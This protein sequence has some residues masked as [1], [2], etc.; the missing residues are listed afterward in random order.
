MPW[1]DAFG[2]RGGPVGHGREVAQDVGLHW[3]VA[4]LAVPA[5]WSP[6]TQ[7]LPGFDVEPVAV[8]CGV[9]RL[10][11]HR[12]PAVVAESDSDPCGGGPD[13]QFAGAPLTQPGVSDQLAGT[14]SPP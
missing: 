6:P 5:A 4:G 9:D 10:G 7:T 1:L 8:H 2:H 11:A 12:G 13:V 14:A 3:L